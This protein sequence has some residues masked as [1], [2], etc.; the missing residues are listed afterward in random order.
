VGLAWRVCEVGFDV[1]ELE[2][3]LA[4]LGLAELGLAELGLAELGL[5]E[6]GLA[7]LGL[8]ELARPCVGRGVSERRS[9]AM[10]ERMT[11]MHHYGYRC[12]SA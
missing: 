10:Q 1:T 12:E 2:L 6:L 4:E 9:L 3:D 7:E 11:R 8:A 5:A